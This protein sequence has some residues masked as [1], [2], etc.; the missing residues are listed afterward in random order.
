MPLLN[1][2]ARTGPQRLVR[3]VINDG[4]GESAG[5]GKS[6]NMQ[7]P[8]DCSSILTAVLSRKHKL[9]RSQVMTESIKITSNVEKLDIMI[10]QSE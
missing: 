2:D 3:E 9:F 1:L 4:V 7:S 5:K 10:M 6:C 8:H